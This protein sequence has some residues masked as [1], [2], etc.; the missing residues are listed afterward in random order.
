MVYLRLVLKEDVLGVRNTYFLNELRFL[1]RF[2][3]RFLESVCEI[4][5]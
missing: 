1:V 4:I 5:G 3:V 2:L